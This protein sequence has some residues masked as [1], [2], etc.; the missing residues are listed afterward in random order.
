MG[1]GTEQAEEVAQ[2]AFVVMLQRLDAVEPGKELGFLL[3]TATYLCQNQRRKA[4]NRCEVPHAPEL[5]ERVA[6]GPTSLD[7]LERKR[8]L[9]LVDSILVTLGDRLRSVFVLHEL[10][11]LTLQEISLL[12][13]IP[14][15]TAASRLRLAREAFK[16]E[17][18]R[19]KRPITLAEE[20]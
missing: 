15:N 17:L 16:A 5:L 7:L 8:A 2:E 3:S 13:D 20:P 4:S 6:Q 10:E 11:Q 1:L 14:P 9:A 19:R 12:L 18:G